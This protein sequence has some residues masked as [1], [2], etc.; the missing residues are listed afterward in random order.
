MQNLRRQSLDPD[1]P[2]EFYIAADARGSRTDY[3]DDQAWLVK[4]GARNQAALSFQTQFGGRAD[5]ACLDLGLRLGEQVVYQQW[6]YARRPAITQFAPNFCK[7]K[8]RPRPTWSWSRVTGRW[9]R[10]RLAANSN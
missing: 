1:A 9:N 2:F 10:G 6:S 4:L 5:L 7:P 3:G 8:P